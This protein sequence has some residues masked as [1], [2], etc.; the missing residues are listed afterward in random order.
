MY[1]MIRYDSLAVDGGASQS[2]TLYPCPE[3]DMRGQPRPQGEGCDIG[4]IERQ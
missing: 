4:A 3:K 1:Y 2:A